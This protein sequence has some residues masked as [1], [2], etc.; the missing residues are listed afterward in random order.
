MKRSLCHLLA[1]PRL[2]ALLKWCDPQGM[3]QLEVELFQAFKCMCYYRLILLPIELNKTVIISNQVRFF[4][5]TI[6]QW[7][8]FF[9]TPPLRGHLSWSWPAKRSHA[10]CNYH[11]NQ[12]YTGSIKGTLLPSSGRENAHIIFV[13][14]LFSLF[15]LFSQCRSCN[16]LKGICPLSFHNLH[17]YARKSESQIKRQFS[18]VTS[19]DLHWANKTYKLK[20][21]VITSI[22]GIPLL[23]GRSS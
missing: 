21:S 18:R 15:I 1:S 6:V 23:R 5:D 4:L 19:H 11:L 22:K 17:T 12:G 10:L 3:E 8:L 2:R 16:V 20:R 9:R 13:I 14:D 7:N